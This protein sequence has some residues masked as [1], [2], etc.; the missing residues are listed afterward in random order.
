MAARILMVAH[1]PTA[2]SLEGRMPSA[3]DTAVTDA[4]TSRFTRRTVQ[5]L[6]G[7]ELRC[8][9]TASTLGLDGQPCPALR[10]LDLGRWAGLPLAHLDPDQLS[11][12][13]T[14]PEFD[15]HGGESA[16]SVIARCASW[17]RDRHPDGITVAV[18]SP[19]VLR[20]TVVAT[21]GAP[22]SAWFSVDAAHLD[23]LEITSND[24]HLRLRRLHPYPDWT[25][26][27]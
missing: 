12:W 21:L 25:T 6:C 23:A 15:A 8:S 2:Q 24:D 27:S 18:T 16:T 5:V 20:A 11:R 14:D 3:D 19:A 17:L 22:P 1:A 9:T 7:P 26:R 10:D 13:T 4:M